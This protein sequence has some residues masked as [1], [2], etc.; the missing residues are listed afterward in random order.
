LCRA[1]QA[2]LDLISLPREKID[3]AGP[4]F[5]VGK[6][7]DIFEAQM[8]RQVFFGERGEDFY[9]SDET[10]GS[11]IVQT[12]LL[13]SNRIGLAGWR[14]PPEIGAVGGQHFPRHAL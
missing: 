8:N 12:L 6:A 10:G 4:R 9:N 7:R 14:H 5:G 1:E 11:R 13:S 2:F 3:Q